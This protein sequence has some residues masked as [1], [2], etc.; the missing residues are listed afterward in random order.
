MKKILLLHAWCATSKDHWYPWLSRE[1]INQRFD[2]YIPQL[3][4]KDSPTLKDWT[5]SVFKNV[6][7]DKN[8]IVIGHSLGSVLGLRLAERYEIKK[9]VL[10]SGWDFWD[11]TPEHETF[12]KTRIDHSKIKE[13]VKE[14]L[15]IHSDT[16]PYITSW[17]AKGFAKR[18]C[19]KFIL[20]EGK[21]H[22]TKEDGVEKLPEVLSVVV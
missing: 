5:K 16:D 4:D 9:L 20:I 17:Q 22:F 2:V 12:F 18:L 11:L 8:T 13:N 6:E 14:R 10:V 15:I 3:K 19:A 1:L 7:L 21:G